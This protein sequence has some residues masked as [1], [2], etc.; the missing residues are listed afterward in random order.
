MANYVRDQVQL[1]EIIGHSGCHNIE[2]GDLCAVFEKPIPTFRFYPQDASP[3]TE[4]SLK[5]A[6]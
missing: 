2:V 1:G 3:P 4:L 5:H 6:I